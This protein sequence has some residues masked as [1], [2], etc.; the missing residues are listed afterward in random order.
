MTFDIYGKFRL[1][2]L[3]EQGGWNAYRVEPGKR[4]RVRDLLIPAS[5]A[6]GDLATYLDDNF[7]ELAQPGQVVELIS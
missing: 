3:R 6:T 5:L 7:H 2:V 1:E 4:V